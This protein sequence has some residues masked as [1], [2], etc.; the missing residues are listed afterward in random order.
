MLDI[1]IQIKQL[2][3]KFLGCGHTIIRV[4]ALDDHT[5]Q[6]GLSFETKLGTET[7]SGRQSILMLS[8]NVAAGM[9]SEDGSAVTH[10]CWV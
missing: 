6:K 10:I 8:I 5:M 1:L 3:E 4:K 7:V 9:V 2:V